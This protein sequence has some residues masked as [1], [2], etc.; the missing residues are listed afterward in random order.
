MEFKSDAGDT[1]CSYTSEIYQGK[2]RIFCF[3]LLKD[4]MLANLDLDIHFTFSVSF[5][6]KLQA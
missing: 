5:I 4:F 2:N 3:L 6:G 1:T